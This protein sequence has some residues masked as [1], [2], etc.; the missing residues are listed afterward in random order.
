[1]KYYGGLTDTI[2]YRLC[3]TISTLLHDVYDDIIF[4]NRFN[5]K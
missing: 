2:D 1:M 3:V 5:T 4:I